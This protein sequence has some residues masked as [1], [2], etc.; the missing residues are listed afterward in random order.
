MGLD[1]KLTHVTDRG[2]W[3]C[4]LKVCTLVPSFKVVDAGRARVGECGRDWIVDIRATRKLISPNR[5]PLPQRS[6]E[7]MGHAFKGRNDLPYP[8]MLFAYFI[9]RI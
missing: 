4:F 5:Y 1:W 9:Q 3:Y 7:G 6:P 8:V 2:F